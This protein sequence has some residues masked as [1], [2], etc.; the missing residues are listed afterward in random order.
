MLN[1]VMLH[2]IMLF[3]EN[4]VFMLSVIMLNVVLLRVVGPQNCD[5]RNI[6]TSHI[7]PCSEHAVLLT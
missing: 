1:A 5:D 6:I 2:V 3:V 7:L 4:D